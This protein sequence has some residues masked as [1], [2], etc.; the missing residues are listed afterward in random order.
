M[1]AILQAPPPTQRYFMGAVAE[2]VPGGCKM[3][4]EG[5]GARMERGED[6]RKERSQGE[7]GGGADL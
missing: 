5:G 2:E 6:M 3:M 7:E 4:R 1:V